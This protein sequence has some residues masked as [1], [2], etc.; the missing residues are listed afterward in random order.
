MFRVSQAPCSSVSTDSLDSATPRF[1]WVVCIKTV[2]SMM[3]CGSG[4][5]YWVD[6]AMRDRCF[7]IPL[8][9][10]DE[11]RYGLIDKI[12]VIL[13][14]E[15]MGFSMIG[16]GGHVMNSEAEWGWDEKLVELLP[17]LYADS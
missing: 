17:H 1:C 8:P 5:L 14:E 12:L 13:G 3:Q 11:V 9:H 16:D 2:V 15:K 10:D 6:L 4:R 7:D